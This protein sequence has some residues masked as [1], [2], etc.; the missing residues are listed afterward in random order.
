MGGVKVERVRRGCGWESRCYC[1]DALESGHAAT[2]S[3]FRKS[4]AQ[5]FQ[6]QLVLPTDQALFAQ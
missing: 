6:R 4:R 1:K 2:I 5:C 3:P